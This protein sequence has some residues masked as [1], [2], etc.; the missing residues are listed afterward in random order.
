MVLGG[1]LMTHVDDQVAKH[2][3]AMIRLAMRKAPEDQ[4]RP[5][6]PDTLNEIIRSLR[7]GPDRLHDLILPKCYPLQDE[8]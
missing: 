6:K 5:R 1:C 2:I 4:E 7:R 8:S 3:Q